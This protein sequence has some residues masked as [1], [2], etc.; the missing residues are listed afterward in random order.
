MD[1]DDDDGIGYI[2]DTHLLRPSGASQTEMALLHVP[3]RDVSRQGSLSSNISDLEE[4]IYE[5]T[6]NRQFQYVSKGLVSKWRLVGISIDG[7]ISRINMKREP[8][9]V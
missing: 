9:N 8:K 3:G 5:R 1:H 6:T 2:A 4:P 7:V